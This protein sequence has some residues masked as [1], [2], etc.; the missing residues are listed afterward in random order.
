MHM[1]ALAGFY[2][3]LVALAVVVLILWICLPFAV[4]G[5]K[6]LLQRQVEL[7]EQQNELLKQMVSRG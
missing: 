1:E 4:F 3:A 5:V 7:L 6:P 2:L